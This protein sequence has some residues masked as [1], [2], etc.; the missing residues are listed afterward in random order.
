M[1]SKKFNLQLILLSSALILVFFA[2]NQ[3][4]YHNVSDSNL[5]KEKD[6][7]PPANFDPLVPRMSYTSDYKISSI[8][9]L[10]ALPNIV[11]EGTHD[12]PYIISN[13]QFNNE[14]TEYGLI[15][16]NLN[17]SL[18]IS[19]IHINKSAKSGIYIS[20]CSEISIQHYIST[21]S[22]RALV[23]LNAS[24][25]ELYNCSITSERGYNFYN[26]TN[27]NISRCTFQTFGDSS[28]FWQRINTI[29][30][31]HSLFFGERRTRF[32][33]ELF[34]KIYCEDT[35]FQRHPVKFSDGNYIEYSN[36]QFSEYYQA[37]GFSIF[38]VET[39]HISGS[40]FFNNSDNSIHIGHS[41]Q[42]HIYNC[43]IY[44]NALYYKY[45]K[46]E[47]SVNKVEQSYGT[48]GIALHIYSC[49]NVTL[50]LNRFS[51]NS[52]GVSLEGNT[53]VL[54]KENTF[55][56]YWYAPFIEKANG[57]ITIIDDQIGKP[58]FWIPTIW[59]LTIGLSLLILLYILGMNYINQEKPFY[60]FD[61]ATRETTDGLEQ[62]NQHVIYTR[63][64]RI[65]YI[66]M[67]IVLLFRPERFSD[68]YLL[69]FRIRYIS[70]Y[71]MFILLFILDYLY[72]KEQ[73]F[74]RFKD[75]TEK[76]PLVSLAYNPKIASL[77][78]FV[79][80]LVLK[81][82]EW[83]MTIVWAEGQFTFLPDSIWFD[84]KMIGICALF[85]FGQIGFRRLL[86]RNP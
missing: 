23:I 24:S 20:N 76:S 56:H 51:Y 47:W 34:D 43:S 63:N 25:V 66:F 1:I 77:V 82:I 79:P 27:L 49:T 81:L 46:T 6:L 10:L 41:T 16:E 14:T 52:V 48:F 62:I 72:Q 54:R 53:E 68:S 64:L 73:Y 60:E 45:W 70:I 3:L 12:S 19:N 31:N 61:K 29:R 22:S 86:H 9:E 36:N 50:E 44:Q 4:H 83:I 13:L 39:V 40:S 42:L 5:V 30:L 67:A 84:G 69:G 26:I 32:Y 2:T 55:D 80:L 78:I 65:L 8:E 7:N 33:I 37:S 28:I 38:N 85:L 15:V 71:I 11:G 17:V 58:R 59:Y 18:L 74:Q 57:K 75:L 35:F 21:A